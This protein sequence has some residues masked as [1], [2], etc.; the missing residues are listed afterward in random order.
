MLVGNSTVLEQVLVLAQA[1]QNIEAA[2]AAIPIGGHIMTGGQELQV[3]GQRLLLDDDFCAKTL[4]NSRW[5]V[6]HLLHQSELGGRGKGSRGITK[7]GR[8][9]G[10][11]LL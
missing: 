1:V 3:F 11:G 10:I 8:E 6:K 7:M 4:L 9:L 5:S 2:P